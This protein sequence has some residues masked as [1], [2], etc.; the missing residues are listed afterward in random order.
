MHTIGA[1]IVLDV[2]FGVWA[3]IRAGEFDWNEVGRF[4]GSNVVP[5]VGGYLTVYVAAEFVPSATALVSEG[6]RTLLWAPLVANLVGSVI[7][8]LKS[9]GIERGEPSP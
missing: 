6:I 9:M 2:L 7:A 5:Y 8:N 4:Y 1:L 3:S